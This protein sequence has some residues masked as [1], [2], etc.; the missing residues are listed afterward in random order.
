MNGAENISS[1]I[2]EEAKEKAEQ[3]LSDARQRAEDI[4]SESGQKS[5]LDVNEIT[6]AAKARVNDIKEKSRLNGGI[7]ARKRIAAEKQ[8]LIQ[9]AFDK[10]R[11]NILSMPGDK[12]AALLGSLAAKAC[13]DGLG[14]ELLL[15]Q[16]DL[17]EHGK[18][19]LDTANEKISG[20]KLTLSADTAD[21]AGGV[22]IRRGNVEINCGIDLILKM[23]KSEMSRDVAECLFGKG[24]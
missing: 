15:S 1:K 9:Q 6:E 2:I 4:I 13:I 14:G 8:R 24:A 17:A 23:L 7:E 10:T 16:K 19:V 12:Y 20:E 21:I 5:K 22:V 3:I 18:N 11:E